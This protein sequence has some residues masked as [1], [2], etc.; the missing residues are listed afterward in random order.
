MLNDKRKL[1]NS[2]HGMIFK[3]F[4]LGKKTEKNIYESIINNYL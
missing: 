3:Y 2:T 1:E 4:F